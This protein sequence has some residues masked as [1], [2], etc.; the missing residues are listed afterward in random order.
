M[1][2]HGD[3]EYDGDTRSS[4]W[5]LFRTLSKMGSC[6]NQNFAPIISC[7]AIVYQF[8]ELQP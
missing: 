2:R 4:R 8:M 6:V 1:R 3:R 7:A 5:G